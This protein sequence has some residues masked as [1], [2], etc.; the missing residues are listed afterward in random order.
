MIT[1]REVLPG[2]P[3]SHRWVV[4]VGAATAGQVPGEAASGSA[5][6]LWGALLR[7]WDP[8][9]GVALVVASDER[10]PR[11]G[12]EV[13]GDDE[14]RVA[15]HARTLWMLAS[16]A[17]QWV[18]WRE[19]RPTGA[20]RT[21]P[22]G[23]QPGAPS[24]RAWPELDLPLVASFTVAARREPVVFNLPAVLR[25]ASQAGQPWAFRL[26]LVAPAGDGT[27]VVG[28][29]AAEAIVTIALHGRPGAVS[30]AAAAMLAADL[31]GPVSLT[32][33]WGVAPQPVELPARA[34]HHLLALP[35]RIA[36]LLPSAD[37]ANAPELSQVVADLPTPHVLFLGATGL[38][39][40]TS[41]VRLGG[42]AIAAGELVLAVDT[43][44][45]AMLERLAARAQRDGR[46]VLH[47]Q[48]GSPAGGVLDITEPPAALGRDLWCESLW[49]L[50]RRDLW[51]T[52]P[53]E[54]FGPV[55]E[56]AIR[57]LIELAVDVA[58][59]GF[60]DA[61]RLLDPSEDRYR[62]EVLA[63]ASKAV[64]RV[65]NREIMPMIRGGDNAALFVTGKFA[66]FNSA[67][68]R[69][70]TAGPGPRVPLEQAL[71]QGISVLVHAPASRLGDIPARTLIAATLRRAWAWLTSREAGPRLNIVL[72]E[73]QRYASDSAT[74]MLAEARKYGGRLLLANQVLTQLSEELRNTVLGNTGAICCY[75]MS[76]RDA[77]TM[78]GLFPSITVHQMQTLPRHTLAVTK[79]ESD[80]VVAGPAPFDELRPAPPLAE[81]LIDL[82]LVPDPARLAVL[83]RLGSALAALQAARTPAPPQER[84]SAQEAAPPHE[85]G[86]PRSGG[87]RRARTLVQVLSQQSNQLARILESLDGVSKVSGNTDKVH[88][89]CDGI[90]MYVDLYPGD[91]G[92]LRVV[93]K[94]ARDLGKPGNKP[95][96]KFCGDL[97]H[98]RKILKFSPV[99]EGVLISAEL[100]TGERSSLTAPEVVRPILAAAIRALA[101]EAARVAAGI[102]D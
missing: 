1:S 74:V 20:G 43:H 53:D 70:A 14:D 85:S 90:D 29:D 99:D 56:K 42:D 31:A 89:T 13:S 65:V 61:S 57:G 44:D 50:I 16:S 5:A 51:G 62:D 18:Q 19:P 37:V 71:E 6:L 91:P 32:P 10:G 49:S 76:P 22:A 88:F 45:G 21:I 67:M 28:E 68:F 64:A 83:T 75:R 59:F 27:P 80:L 97:T 39:K 60:A 94:V 24:A 47:V 55:G 11:V 98:T 100:I 7:V 69:A 77:A 25:T 17:M 81:Q 95:A 23:G 12:L 92:Y 46:P 66:P 35:V 40:S 34:L 73:W 26:E 86:F 84:E 9:T 58:D 3:E 101:K 38:G 78:D 102:A 52:M 33:C 48:F 79:F 8:A 96:L 4:E 30:T 36:P 87:L 63:R 82:G 54:F 72:D 41:L 93:T 15:H 2:L